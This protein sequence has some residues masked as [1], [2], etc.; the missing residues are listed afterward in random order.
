MGY[1]YLAPGR[2]KPRGYASSGDVALAEIQ[3]ITLSGFKNYA[4]ASGFTITPVMSGWTPAGSAEITLDDGVSWLDDATGLAVKL[5]AAIESDAAF[6]GKVSVVGGYGSWG[7]GRHSV[8]SGT[9]LTIANTAALLPG[10][11]DFAVCCWFVT[12]DLS[13][14][15]NPV[16]KWD[17]AADWHVQMNSNGS[18]QL[19]VFGDSG[20][21]SAIAVTA[22]G[23]IEAGTLYFIYADYQHSTKTIRISVND[24]SF[25]TAT[26]GWTTRGSANA[27]LKIGEIGT[28]GRYWNG[29][30][31]PVGYWIGRRLSAGE[32]TSLYNGGVPKGYADLTSGEK[33]NLTAWWGMTSPDTLTAD[34]SGN[35][36]TL[37][38]NNVKWGEGSITLTCTYDSSL[39]DLAEMTIEQNITLTE[40]VASQG[41]SDDPATA[42]IVVASDFAMD[43]NTDITFGADGT[44]SIGTIGS[45]IDTV[46]SVPS[47][48]SVTNG[49][50]GFTSIELTRDTT[51]A[52]GSDPT[53]VSGGSANILLTDGSDGSPGS[54]ELHSIIS[55]RLILTGGTYSIGGSTTNYNAIP[56]VSGWSGDQALSD[57]TIIMTTDANGDVADDVLDPQDIDLEYP[58][59]TAVVETVQDGG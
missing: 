20:G 34:E 35:G 57:G 56:S 38:N 32:I 26:G 49:G 39:G 47:N 44:L 18:I 50:A 40:G 55:S 33:T 37:T 27:A 25:A 28:L 19:A 41:V 46:S 29:L 9:Y 48:W 30:I 53:G 11:G 7:M 59:I 15:R 4:Y 23:V 24:G 22:A 45:T 13:A 3:T 10:D 2:S 58:T 42:A 5:Q 8:A 51:G 31:G 16:A 21:S 52:L 36:F 54:P 43:G 17:V 14:T 1:G 12:D 6:T